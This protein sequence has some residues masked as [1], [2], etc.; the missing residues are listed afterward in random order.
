MDPSRLALV[1]LLAGA[2]T[3]AHYAFWSWRLRSLPR[4][5]ELLFGETPD[6]W[7][8]ALGRRRP[9]G[10]ARPIPVL[11]VHG[12]AANRV[13]L[14]FGVERWSLAAHLARAGFDCFALD[15]RGH[16]ASRRA[17]GGAPRSWNFDDY[18][19]QDVPAALDAIRAA[20]G[21]PRVLWVGHS[22]G[23]LLGVAACAAYPDRVAGLVTLGSPVFWDVQDRLRLLVRFGFLLSGRWN[24]FLARSLAP[25]S[26]YW[27]LPVS[28]IAI[29]GRNVT[30]PVYRRVLANVVENISPGVLAQ[31][32]RW[33]ATDT[34]AALDGAA[35][36]RAA[37]ARC[38]QPALF[39]S[40]DADPIAP[41]AVV[42]RAAALWGGPSAVLRFGCTA[43]STVQYGHTDLLLGEH[44]P[45]EVF[46]RIEAW[47]EE[48]ALDLARGEARPSAGPR[49]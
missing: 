8:V 38:R 17:R 1:A 33:I 39:V 49:A 4:E 45:E 19:R 23:G 13:S 30:R 44:A 46:P 10:G 18:L 28:E 20:T 3:W 21:A 31:F 36:Y 2:A 26:G 11:L 25:F 35:D 12:I 27:H 40:A 34:F 15:L 22:Q 37:M 24:R 48:A 41:P 6:G 29:N 32:G 43:G 7:R 5:D 47:L 42:A 9:R 14:D 16:G